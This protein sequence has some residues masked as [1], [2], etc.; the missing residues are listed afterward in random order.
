MRKIVTA[1]AT[2]FMLVTNA[3]AGQI[4]LTMDQVRPY[5]IEQ[6]AGN[7]VIGNPAIADITV[8]DNQ[9][10]LL[11][12]KSPGLT[13]IFIFDEQGNTIEN[14]MVR[15]RSQNSDMLTFYHGA[16]RTTYNCTSNCEVTITVGDTP[17][18]FETTIEQ[19]DKKYEQA[20]SAASK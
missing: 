20:Q 15:V 12:G 2:L 17:K 5:Q 6:P 3:Q 1:L 14:V 19:V 10:I 8:Q 16:A 13:N 4:W 9:N 7:I 18:A 11:F